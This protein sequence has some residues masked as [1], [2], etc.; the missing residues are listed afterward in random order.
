MHKNKSN[1]NK[2][3]P[4]REAGHSNGQLS[5][6]SSYTRKTANPR[7][8]LFFWS[9]IIMTSIATAS[10][11]GISGWES[12]SI[13]VIILLLLASVFIGWLLDRSHNSVIDN[14]LQG[15]DKQRSHDADFFDQVLPVWSKQI[16]TSRHA[17]NNAVAE[18]TEL[19]SGIVSR[20]KAILKTSYEST[21]REHSNEK[22]FLET[23]AHS[24]TN[25]QTIFKDLK[26]ALE[27]V[28]DSKDMLLAEVTMYSANMKEMAEESHHVA[29][30]SQIIALNAEIEAARAGEAGRA[31][32]AVVS[33]MRQLARQSGETSKKMNEKVGSINAAMSRF[34]GEDK[35][36]STKE[37]HYLSNAE[38]MFKNVLEDFNK[39][40]LKM[41]KSID[42]MESESRHIQDD[43]SSALIALQF[44]DS[45]SQVMAHVA[46][47]INALNELTSV[48]TQDLDADKWLEEMKKEFSVDSEHSNLR[49]DLASST[50]SSSLTFF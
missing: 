40:T 18:L 41:E 21:N 15:Q 30:Q 28:S 39:V 50:Q 1:T 6:T 31:F 42:T 9:P 34:Y 36:M 25:I 27:T 10:L 14:L 46:D 4:Q 2:A 45:V 33:E 7:Y 37:A 43:I 5:E 38:G 13:T 49:D 16:N 19:F 8:G 17:G 12:A 23:V 3:K 22:D 26:A 29:F 20:L 32:A 11:I 47:N 44:Q 35:E 24:Q 48:G